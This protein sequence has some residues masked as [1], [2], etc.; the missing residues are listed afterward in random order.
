MRKIWTSILL[1]GK[2]RRFQLW[3]IPWEYQFQQGN[4]GCSSLPL[5]SEFGPF[6]QYGPIF[7][8][9]LTSGLNFELLILISSSQRKFWWIMSY[10]SWD[11]HTWNLFGESH[12][13]WRKIFS[14]NPLK[15]TS[16]DIWSEWNLNFCLQ[17][18][19]DSPNKFQMPISQLLEEMIK[20][21]TER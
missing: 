21:F 16:S 5:W 4:F 7:G 18:W 20:T 14:F 15:S 2:D 17:N 11:I 10:K 9:V 8:P 6:V 3:S 19:C 12:Q 1:R 13:F